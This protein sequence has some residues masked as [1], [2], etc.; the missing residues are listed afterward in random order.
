MYHIKI[1]SAPPFYNSF[2]F[3]PGLFNILVS[4]WDKEVHAQISTI[5]PSLSDST[6]LGMLSPGED[7]DIG[8]RMVLQLLAESR[9]ETKGHG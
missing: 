9:E 3:K 2:R 4:C 5:K 1:R 8:A 6:I 7:D